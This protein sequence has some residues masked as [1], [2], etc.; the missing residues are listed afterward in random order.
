MC[1]R[2]WKK[3]KKVTAKW[4]ELVLNAAKWCEKWEFFSTNFAVTFLLWSR[5]LPFAPVWSLLTVPIDFLLWFE[6]V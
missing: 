3:G 6:M 5:L 4:C 1:G 2:T